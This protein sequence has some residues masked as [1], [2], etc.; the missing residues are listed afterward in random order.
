MSSIEEWQLEAVYSVMRRCEALSDFSA[1]NFTETLEKMG[2]TIARR[3]NSAASPATQKGK[4]M[5]QKRGPS[6]DLIIY[7]EVPMAE[8]PITPILSV[9]SEEPSCSNTAPHK[10]HVWEENEQVMGCVG[11]RDR[12]K[13]PENLSEAFE[14]VPVHSTW[15]RAI[16]SENQ[17]NECRV[18]GIFFRNRPEGKVFFVQYTDTWDSPSHMPFEVFVETWERV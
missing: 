5:T 15:I 4:P 13:P 14:D 16:L 3:T 2:Y 9:G 8:E 10:R 17:S 11:V 6:A 1:E 12:S 18:T 7:D